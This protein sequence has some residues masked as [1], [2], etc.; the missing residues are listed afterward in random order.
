MLFEVVLKEE[1]SYIFDAWGREEEDDD[2]KLWEKV[3][4]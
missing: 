2:G 1:A 4:R 3:G